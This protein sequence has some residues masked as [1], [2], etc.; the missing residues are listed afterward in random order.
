MH[1]EDRLVF[2]WQTKSVVKCYN[3]NTV[4]SWIEKS[5]NPNY[6]MI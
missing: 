6:E 4:E 3:Q 5:I 1:E 2:Q